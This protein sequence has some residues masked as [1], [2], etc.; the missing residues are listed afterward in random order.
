MPT[1]IAPDLS[2]LPPGQR[3]ID[4]LT[5]ETR[6]RDDTRLMLDRALT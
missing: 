5:G 2:N 6:S 1:V 4:P 3:A